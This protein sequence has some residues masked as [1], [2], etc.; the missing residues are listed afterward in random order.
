M[1]KL[2]FIFVSVFYCLSFLPSS[3]A[4]SDNVGIKSVDAEQAREIIEK[5]RNNPDFLIIDVRTPEEYK[6][7]HIENAVNIDYKSADFKNEVKK[8]NKDDTYVVY[9]HSGRRAKLSADI[10]GQLGFKN[11][12]EIGGVV[13]WQ[14]AGYKLT[15][16]ESK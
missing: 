2:I 12:Y 13:Q 9:C 6:S 1:N 5:N 7:G 8:L 11:I 4:I 15:E 3:Q 14:E 16:M 10:M